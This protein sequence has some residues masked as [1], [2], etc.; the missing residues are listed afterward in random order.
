MYLRR[1]SGQTGTRRSLPRALNKQVAATLDAA[2]LYVS[3]S[4]AN[5]ILLCINVGY[6]KNLSVNIGHT[7][8]LCVNIGYTRSGRVIFG[9]KKCIMRYCGLQDKL[10][11]V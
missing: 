8:N 10:N 1:D 5:T 6:M 3:T 7:K 4:V 2:T 9:Y 11:F